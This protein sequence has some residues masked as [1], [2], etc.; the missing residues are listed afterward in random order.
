MTSVEA[1]WESAGVTSGLAGLRCE[2][3]THGSVTSVEAG[4]EAAGVNVGGL[5]G[6]RCEKLL[7]TAL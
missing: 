2:V 5:K 3:L 6:L 4:G 1:G 7:R